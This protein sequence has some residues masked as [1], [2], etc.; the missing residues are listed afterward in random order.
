MLGADAAVQ[1]VVSAVLFIARV[2]E[3]IDHDLASQTSSE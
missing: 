2:V 3:E 1:R